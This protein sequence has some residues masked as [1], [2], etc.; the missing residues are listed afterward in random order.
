MSMSLP[1][2]FLVV[3]F[4][5]WMNR[6]QQAVI[7]CLKTENEILKSQIKDQG[8]APATDRTKSGDDWR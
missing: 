3:V 1:M 8:T 2:H 4:A 5:G 7:D 6:Q